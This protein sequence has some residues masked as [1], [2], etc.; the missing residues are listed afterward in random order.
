MTAVYALYQTGDAAQQAV[1]GLRAVGLSDNRITV[2]TGEPMEDYEFSHIGKANKLWWVASGGGLAGLFAGTSL[3]V[4][5]SSDWPMNVGNMS[6]VAWWPNLIVMFEL[7]MLGAILATVA[8]VVIGNGLLRRRPVLYD[9]EVTNGRI[10]VGVENADDATRA[11]V[12]QALL[13]VPGI[14]VRTLQAR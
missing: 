10:L 12:E 3:T 13:V 9:P 1:D 7:T 6:T 8:T 4:Y 2:I 5:T 11:V 14:E